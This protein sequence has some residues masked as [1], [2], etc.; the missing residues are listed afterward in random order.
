[1]NDRDEVRRPLAHQRDSDGDG[2]SDREE[3]RLGTDPGDPDTDHDGTGDGAEVRVG[4]DPLHTAPATRD[5]LTEEVAGALGLDPRDSRV[6][7]AVVQVK[8]TMW[9]VE[10]RPQH[11]QR[12]HEIVVRP[13]PDAGLSLT[14]RLEKDRLRELDK[15]LDDALAKAGITRR[16]TLEGFV[17]K[18]TLQLGSIK[19]I[20]THRWDPKH[21]T[22]TTTTTIER[23][24]GSKSEAFRTV[25]FGRNSVTVGSTET[26]SDG[27]VT[28]TGEE[29]PTEPS[30]ASA[31]PTL[32]G[33]FKASST[34]VDTTGGGEVVHRTWTGPDGETKLE[35]WSD[36][37]KADGSVTSHSM[38]YDDTGVIYQ[39]DTTTHADGSSTTT[40][41][42]HVGE[43]LDST[44]TTS[45]HDD[46]D[47]GS[48]DGSD[49]GS[50]NGSGN[51]SGDGDTATA[52]TAADDTG[53]QVDLSVLG[54]PT[55]RQMLGHTAPNGGG[56]EIVLNSDG[57]PAIRP[58]KSA[59]V[60]DPPQEGEIVIALRPLRRAGAGPEFGPQGPVVIDVTDF[61]PPTVDPFAH[62]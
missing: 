26:A 54:R 17:H 30:T 33:V 58:P 35:T 29:A 50:D 13:D 23:A 38:L 47:G 43:T 53:F 57:T 32:F 11:E 6:A 2:L 56:I 25:D 28:H 8:K 42:S 5:A 19:A 10:V 59:G 39:S 45:P 49:D 3:R 36:E 61:H 1:M 18:N 52:L 31:W 34:S 60:T 22:S 20:S 27:T 55:R 46:D 41:K 48:D 12:P 16:E 9:H 15:M 21:L 40:S 4:T 37:P 24:D 44:D 51:G 7:D 14:E 62:R